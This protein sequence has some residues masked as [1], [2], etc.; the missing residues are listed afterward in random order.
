MTDADKFSIEGGLPPMAAQNAKQQPFNEPAPF[1]GFEID[2]WSEFVHTEPTTEHGLPPMP[3]SDAV[4][5]S[6]WN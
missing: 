6:P 5:Q 4:E 2:S 1:S 3:A